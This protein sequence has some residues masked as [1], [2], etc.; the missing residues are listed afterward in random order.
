MIRIFS[1][2]I[3]EDVFNLICIDLI[4]EKIAKVFFTSLTS[5]N[6]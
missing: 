4:R 1:A 6:V 5:E 3:V 2:K